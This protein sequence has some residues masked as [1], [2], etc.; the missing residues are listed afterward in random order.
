M[1]RLNGPT[2]PPLADRLWPTSLSQVPYWAFQDE[3][4]LRAEHDRLFHGPYWSYLCLEA[5]LAQPGDYCTTFIG[6]QPV[7]VTRDVDGEVYAF[8]N[9]CAH[10]GALIA[11]ADHG[12]A[13]D[14]TCVYHAWTYNL[15]GDLTAVAFQDGIGGKGGMPPEF[16][17]SAHG[18]RKLR[19]ATVN[20]LV[21]GSLSNDVPGIEE[22]LGEQVLE[23]IDR[24]LGG[25]TP[26]VLGR[27][28]QKLPNNWKLYV[29]NVKDSYH[30]SILHLFFTTFGINKLSQRGGIIVDESGGH[31][32]S[33]S[34]ID[35][36]ADTD[37][38]YSQQNIR[39]ESEYSLVDP[40]MLDGFSE[41]GDDV[42]LQ[43][44][45]VFPGFVLQQIQNSVAVRQILPRAVD[46]TTLNWTYLGFDSDTEAQRLTRLKQS[47]LVGPAGY[48]SMEDGCI[49]GF[50]QR[51]I[52]GAGH[53]FATLQMGG[54]QAVSSESR[55]TEASVR[56]FW[57]AYRDGMGFTL[58]DQ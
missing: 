21:F 42:T 12:H 48:V 30:A 52:A 8:E 1:D 38:D 51:G 19:L 32:V 24:V 37:A 10:R 29:E 9:R 16:C 54:D 28:T 43:I 55:V 50:V 41:V 5:E 13:K 31:H 18:P 57:K 14:F 26:V 35:R 45:S 11:M 3:D 56:G 44:L 27:F 53:E 23:K 7:L 15:Q 34:A 33:Y 6:E 17:L 36:T 4:V 47:N 39:S 46:S 25:R 2:A 49:G 58:E 22:Y 40:S 20:G